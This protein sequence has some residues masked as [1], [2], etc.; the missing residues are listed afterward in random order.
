ML[1]T[2]YKGV[3]LLL[4]CA[5]VFSALF[6][7]NA[8]SVYA[9]ETSLTLEQI[10][11]RIQSRPGLP[12][13]RIDRQEGDTITF[14][15]QACNVRD[16][17]Q[18]QAGAFITC[19]V[20]TGQCSDNTS[21]PTG[22]DF[23]SS[24]SSAFGSW[25]GGTLITS[26]AL[27]MTWLLHAILFFVGLSGTILEFAIRH[28]VNDMSAY[29]GYGT[30]IGG[31]IQIAW[32]VIRDLANL[33][34]IGGL[35]WASIAMILSL[36]NVKAGQLIVKILLAA[37]LVNFSY[38]FAGAI[39]DSSN[40]LS[41]Q[42]Y[43]SAIKMESDDS[44]IAT[45]ARNADGTIG[46]KIAGVAGSFLTHTKLMTI[47]DPDA[48]RS[49]NNA[50]TSGTILFVSLLGI[51]LSLVTIGVFVI[52]AF[53]L[54][55]RFIVLI[56][57]LITSPI[58]VLGF[59]G[60]PYVGKWGK[61]WWETLMS[62]CFFAPIYFLMV[63]LSLLIIREA[64]GVL[65]AGA[66]T[67]GSY[68]TFASI[69][70]ST[71]FESE[72]STVGL[73]VLFIIATGLMVASALVAHKIANSFGKEF[74]GLAQI[75]GGVN[76]VRNW[77]VSG[78]G[79][80]NRALGRGISEVAGMVGGE[81]ARSMTS[82]VYKNLTLPITAVGELAASKIKEKPVIT[83][84]WENYYNNN[85]D[86]LQ[87][88]VKRV[89]FGKRILPKQEFI[90]VLTDPE[91][92]KERIKAISS[93]S[94]LNDKEKGELG[95]LINQLNASELAEILP[96]LITKK[97]K[98]NVAMT[99]DRRLLQEAREK[100]P[101]NNKNESGGGSADT[102]GKQGTP[103]TQEGPGSGAQLNNPTALQGALDKIA[104][105][106]DKTE[107]NTHQLAVLSAIEKN[108]KVLESKSAMQSLNGKQ[109]NEMRTLLGTQKGGA[110]Q[111][112]VAENARY[113]DMRVAMSDR[114]PAVV[115]EFVKGFGAEETYPQD[116]AQNSTV[117]AAQGE[118]KASPAGI[119][120]EVRSPGPA[121]NTK[122]ARR[123][124]E[125]KQRGKGG[126]GNT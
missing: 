111:I 71:D 18:R 4:C 72:G 16:G 52:G 15:R 9:N 32:S 120:S 97:Q 26:I 53:L 74:A 103:P 75:Y 73:F 21:R 96:Q 76:R 6:F 8:Q 50:D 10:Q 112:K 122:R 115:R 110:D 92:V 86:E 45:G 105:S 100:I 95:A 116:I 90:S 77:A 68:T 79:T 98:D 80:G 2:F 62:Q 64:A 37:L 88:N 24:V 63:G 114:Q 19:S 65:G 57:L 104:A 51:I 89:P 113:G 34:F 83:P 20:S 66:G 55:G 70:T 94:E 3:F 48:L 84:K 93:K 41:Y 12:P 67:E 46:A 123:R 117:I 22:A 7:V 39:I 11:E 31:A 43:K 17:C 47:L 87:E 30:P 91:A 106:T 78:L 81:R 13:F 60:L 56:I 126:K 1:A 54:I 99:A 59:T 58:G 69:L 14:Q 61:E 49:A 25:A 23:V 29:I 27:I 125:G 101:N 109:F 33:L 82:S 108:P 40:F 28:L 85:W 118:L 102:V 35:V 119:V 107:R 42:I 5:G 121:K 38:F 36:P 124:W 44:T